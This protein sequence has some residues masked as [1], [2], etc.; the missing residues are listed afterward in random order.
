MIPRRP[1]KWSFSLDVNYSWIDSFANQ[2]PGGDIEIVQD[3]WDGGPTQY[4]WSS[5][6]LNGLTDP[7]RIASRAAALKAIFDGAML[8]H[9]LGDYQRSR[10]LRPVE[11]LDVS[12]DA[13]QLQYPFEP[14]SSAWKAWKF[15]PLEDPF[16]H[17]VSILLFLAHYCGTTKNMLLFLGANDVSWISLYALKDFMAN[18]GLSETDM[19]KAGGVDVADL[20]IFRQTAN[21]FAAIGPYARHGELGWKPPAKPMPLGTA[22]K[23]IL[24]C[25]SGFLSLR[26]TSLNLRGEFKLKVR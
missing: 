13:F 15:D 6:H 17:P 7:N 2:F 12:F 20:R 24:A 25:V 8:V 9:R 10:L 23:L 5:P 22:T 4:R 14:F 19:A 3:L 11:H 21:N 18:E 26:A 1:L 16:R